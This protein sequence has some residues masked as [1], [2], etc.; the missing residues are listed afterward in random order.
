MQTD[1][2][3]TLQFW[4]GVALIVVFYSNAFQK[5]DRPRGMLGI[6]FNL[7]PD[8]SV[9][10]F[11]NTYFYYTILS[12][13]LL[14]FLSIYVFLNAISPEMLLGMFQVFGVSAKL[15]EGTGYSLLPIYIAA[16]FIGV[17]SFPY[18]EKKG[19]I[20]FPKKYI[21]GWTGIPFRAIEAKSKFYEQI[22][23]RSGKGNN[24]LASEIRSIT[25]S[26]GSSH[27][28][29]SIDVE[30]FQKRIREKSVTTLVNESDATRR[31]LEG[32]LDY[33]LYALILSALR[34]GGMKSVNEVAKSLFCE[35]VHLREEPQI[36]AWF[37]ISLV[38]FFGLFSV[39]LVLVTVLEQHIVK[40]GAPI[41]LT[42][43]VYWPNR[44]IDYIKEFFISQSLLLFISA[45]A[46]IIRSRNT[47][48]S[49]TIRSMIYIAILIIILIIFADYL[50]AIYERGDTTN[51]STR[52][53][54]NTVS[55][56]IERFP[57]FFFHA[58][59][60]ALVSLLVMKISE[61]MRNSRFKLAFVTSASAILLTIF[62]FGIWAFLWIEFQISLFDSSQP[63]N[64]G[65]MEEIKKKLEQYRPNFVFLVVLSSLV[66]TCSCVL[67]AIFSRWE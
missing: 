65:A 50:K 40:I 62:T 58:L 5:I 38:V 22:L 36:D 6:E 7:I 46:L 26:F 3:F 53:V 20:W 55:F 43:G 28:A 8:L 39:V 57:Y 37:C 63:E 41:L 29:A 4:I 32:L 56:I 9:R 45:T 66:S 33:T 17:A 48:Y 47:K 61:Q 60:I 23:D 59:S 51:N 67:S 34:E 31:E 19:P 49:I 18:I 14:L 12:L 10:D 21:H 13:Y 15:P 42:D 24:K 11:T 52:K 64:V 16:L 1:L 54:S 35:E 2:I 44:S 30:F 25:D 27:H